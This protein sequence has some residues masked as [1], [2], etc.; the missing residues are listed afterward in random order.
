MRWTLVIDS[1]QFM[2]LIV[3]IYFR[4]LYNKKPRSHLVKT[5]T[6]FHFYLITF[7]LGNNGLL[8]KS[9]ILKNQNSLHYPYL[10]QICQIEH[11]RGAWDLL[12]SRLWHAIIKPVKRSW[13][14]IFWL[15]II[16]FL[17]RA[18]DSLLLALLVPRLC[19]H[20]PETCI[21]LGWVTC[22]WV[23]FL[24]LGFQLSPL[25]HGLLK[26][27]FLLNHFFFKRCTLQD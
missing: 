8:S 9:Y 15:L 17:F 6:L 21:L 10:L 11:E 5:P 7:W 16:M 12:L 1:C 2:I 3:H 19:V 14:N 20:K 23:Y 22:C 24:V 13:T 27:I 4:I 18:W 25:I 26:D